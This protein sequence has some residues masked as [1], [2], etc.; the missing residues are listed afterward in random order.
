M[1]DIKE[2]CKWIVSIN[3]DRGYVRC[4]KEEFVVGHNG[5]LM[6]KSCCNCYES[7]GRIK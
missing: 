7:K 2:D 4:E 6:C 1:K 5:Y 3:R